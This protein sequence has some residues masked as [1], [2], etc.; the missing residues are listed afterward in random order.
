MVERKLGSRVTVMLW[1]GWQ[2]PKECK[3]KQCIFL[4]G[5]IVESRLCYSAFAAEHWHLP[6]EHHLEA[7]PRE[8]GRNWLRW[9]HQSD[10]KTI[11]EESWHPNPWHPLMQKDRKDLRE[12]CMVLWRPGS[13]WSRSPALTLFTV[14]LL[15][16]PLSQTLWLGMLIV[17]RMMPT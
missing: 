13:A 8:C 16:Q 17:L 11:H 3:E 6:S 15:S 2:R 7:P 10:S 12:N 9:S 14:L 1:G 5:G 4:L